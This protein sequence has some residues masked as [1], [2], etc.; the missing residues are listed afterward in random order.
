MGVL[1]KQGVIS[2]LK[3]ADVLECDYETELPLQISSMKN[4]YICFSTIMLP[5]SCKITESGK[6]LASFCA[7]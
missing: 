2:F 1:L 4:C 6:M 5:I 3:P 7:V